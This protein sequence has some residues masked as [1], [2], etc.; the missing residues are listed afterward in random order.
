MDE[1]DRLEV[2]SLVVA[3]RE[4]HDAHANLLNYLK[5]VGTEVN[6]QIAIL[7]NWGKDD[8]RKSRRRRKRST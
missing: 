7:E 6:R 5:E 3:S 8:P 1:R 4:I 2:K